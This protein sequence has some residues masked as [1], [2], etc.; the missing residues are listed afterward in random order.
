MIGPLVDGIFLRRLFRN[1]KV[2]S[3]EHAID[4][5]TAADAGSFRR[6][7]GWRGDGPEDAEIA[8]MAYL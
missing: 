2:V 3:V 5:A 8:D 7:F 6:W 4:A 1:K